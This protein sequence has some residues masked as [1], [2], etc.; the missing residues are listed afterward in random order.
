MPFPLIGFLLFSDTSVL[1][2]SHEF[3]SR[4]P[5][6]QA[7]GRANAQV[8]LCIAQGWAVWSRPQAQEDAEVRV[9]GGQTARTQEGAWRAVQGHL[10]PWMQDERPYL[11]FSVGLLHTGFGPLSQVEPLQCTWPLCC[12]HHMCSF[13]FILSTAFQRK[14]A[15]ANILQ[16]K[17]Q[18]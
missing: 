6:P 9:R 2:R 10:H 14:T 17:N 1:K 16:V 4:P 5:A 13:S 3:Y 7:S 8:R 18:S 12:T 11:G 15:V